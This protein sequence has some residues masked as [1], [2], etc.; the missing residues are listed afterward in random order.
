MH[1]QAFIIFKDLAS[2]TAA[3]RSLQGFPFYGMPMVGAV[4]AMPFVFYIDVITWY[5]FCL[6][7]LLTFFM[8]FV[9]SLEMSLISFSKFFDYIVT[10]HDQ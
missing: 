8:L 10:V 1:G 5:G 3:L 4:F 6:F 7:L 2:A 9:I